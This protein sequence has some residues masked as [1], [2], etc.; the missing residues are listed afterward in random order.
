[1]LHPPK[2]VS[3]EGRQHR[4]LA[5]CYG[6]E[7]EINIILIKIMLQVMGFIAVM[8]NCGLIGLSGPVHRIFPNITGA[9]TVILDMIIQGVFF[10]WYPPK[11]S[12][13]K[14]VNLG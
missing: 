12:K 11:S 13:Y 6:G 10:N 14:K 2:A 9:Q 1:M 8:V 3:S 4:L 5:E 7:D